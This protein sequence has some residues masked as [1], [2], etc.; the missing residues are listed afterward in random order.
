MK[1][2]QTAGEVLLSTG[3]PPKFLPQ[4]EPSQSQGPKSPAVGGTM[5]SDVTCFLSG[6]INN[7]LELGGLA[8]LKPRTPTTVLFHYM[9]P[10]TKSLKREKQCLNLFRLF[11]KLFFIFILIALFR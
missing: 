6:D 1:D 3:S 5:Y 2:R 9:Y 7:K 4:V 8:V 11:Q 10:P